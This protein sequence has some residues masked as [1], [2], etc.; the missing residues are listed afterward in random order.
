M[1]LLNE[2]PFIVLRGL[3]GLYSHYSTISVHT[4]PEIN[5]HDI[6]AMDLNISRD[7][8]HIILI[9]AENEDT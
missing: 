1:V 2:I 6:L 8:A 3:R 9:S 5:T 4:Y 7:G